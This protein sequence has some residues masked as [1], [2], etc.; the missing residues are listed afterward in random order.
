[1]KFWYVKKEKRWIDGKEFWSRWKAGINAVT[2]LE[3][4]RSQLVFSWI[5]IIG[6]LCGIIVSII[7]VK[8]LW[9]LLIIL[10]AALGN[11]IVGVIGIYQKYSLLL[12]HK[13][14][15]DEAIKGALSPGK[16]SEGENM[17]GGQK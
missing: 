3:Q 5:T 15:M 8:N 10:I 4:T 1:M 2:P 14:L 13:K 12:Q 11:S 9:W 17:K 6:V 16:E 7:S